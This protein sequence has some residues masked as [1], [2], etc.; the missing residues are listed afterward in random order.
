MTAPYRTDRLTRR[1]ASLGHSTVLR[2]AVGVVGLLLVAV[3]APA[4]ANAARADQERA[5]PV[6]PRIPAPA[7]FDAPAGGKGG[8]S[9]PVANCTNYR[10]EPR[11]RWTLTSVAT[12]WSRTWSW[13]GA[14]PGMYFPRVKPGIYRSE[15]TVK[16]RTQSRSRT[17]RVHVGEK[18]AA[19]TVSRSEWR[20]IRRGM[21]R[22]QVADIV[23]NPGRDP[24]RYGGKTTWTYDM[25]P[26]WAWSLVSYRD[27]RVVSKMWN[28]GHD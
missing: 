24:F 12:G 13:R 18:T 11:T 10:V 14:L 5:V 19:G 15:T 17:H 28:V 21:T 22:A 2:A 6:R 3:L 4:T 27:G 9:N 8:V 20:Q 23:G 26:F 25:M 16:C 7:A 1:T